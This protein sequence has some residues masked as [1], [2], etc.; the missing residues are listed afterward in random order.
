[1]RQALIIDD[2]EESLAYLSSLLSGSGWQVATARHGAEALFLARKTPPDIAISDLLMP[3][4]DGYTLLR[5]WKVDPA[6]QAIPFV[7]YTATYTEAAD[8]RLAR[9]LG[10]DA[11]ILKP[12]EPDA[13]IER[14]RQVS[15][16]AAQPAAPRPPTTNPEELLKVY[17]ET[18]VRKLEE[19]SLQLEQANQTL[20]RELR[21]LK[22]TE[23]KIRRTS[24]LLLAV[25]DGIPDTVFV[26]DLQGRYLLFNHG[27]C[28][29]AGKPMEEV[30]GHD[31]T[32]LFP[33]EQAR[34]LMDNDREVMLSGKPCVFEEVLTSRN[35]TGT[36]LTT[37][38]PYRDNDGNVIGIIGISRDIS[39]QR[40]LEQQIFRVQRMES[41]G[42]L[43]G[44]I[45]HDL[46]NVLTPILMAV[47]LLQI[48]EDDP[49]RLKLL[50][51]IEGSAKR[52]ADMLRQ[53]LSFARGVAGRREDIHAG[54][55]IDEVSGIAG[56][57]FLKDIQVRREIDPELWRI[58]ADPTQLHQVL[59]NL[60]INARDAMPAGGTLTLRAKNQTLDQGQANM[61]PEARPGSYVV[62]DVQDTGDG[63]PP[64]VAARIFEPFFSTKA[65][66]KG[67]G[68]GLSTSHAIVQSHGGFVRVSSEPGKGTLLR[69]FLPAQPA[70]D[71]VETAQP[72][73]NGELI[74]VVEH[75]AAV[76]QMI[77]QT[78]EA[79]GY[80]VQLASDKLGA[81]SVYVVRQHE[82]A[83]VII[84]MS[85][86]AAE[87]LATLAVLRNINP[88]A[89]FIAACELSEQPRVAKAAG[90]GLEHFLTKPYS[91][92]DLLSTVH[93]ALTGPLAG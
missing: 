88:K 61:H 18:L 1:M 51:T 73:G 77:R 6:L 26:K 11:F 48:K 69:V 80:R 75:E 36:Y 55:L 5:H 49:R 71:A 90:A 70:G 3:V 66:G 46:N 86:P 25:A 43:A 23:E 42:T 10:A 85:L 59:L 92:A 64:E 27:A 63:M 87:G 8:E 67:S 39:E 57:T 68:L 12:C 84:D 65:A 83:A 62:L 74:L 82:V 37:K 45:A 32:V 79:F 58:K 16:Q 15:E 72:R 78:L 34:K 14:L 20:Q 44:G 41:I 81:E 22:A 4:M 19:K 33:P 30:L 29:R 54:D 24:S 53:V 21:A 28:Q 38:A 2:K 13:F 76:R 9:S 40:E 31:D 17:N 50:A 47:D 7:V 60:A 52:G 35:S 91:S 89:H 56:G 93:Q